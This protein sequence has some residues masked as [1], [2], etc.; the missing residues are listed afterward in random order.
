LWAKLRD[1]CVYV[2]IWLTCVFS[3]VSEKQIA[4]ACPVRRRLPDP[5]NE[6]STLIRNTSNQSAQNA[7]PEHT[8][9]LQNNLEV[10]NS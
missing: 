6:G 3:S 5:E 4:F 8:C 10:I 1:K 9:T 7:I 2:L